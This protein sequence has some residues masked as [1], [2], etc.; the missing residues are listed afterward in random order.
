MIL[1]L[2]F[3]FVFTAFSAPPDIFGT[4]S[5]YGYNKIA[6]A[7]HYEDVNTLTQEGKLRLKQLQDDSY[8]CKYKHSSIFSCKKFIPTENFSYGGDVSALLPFSF[9]EIEFP[10]SHPVLEYS[11]GDFEEWYLNQK[12][13]TSGDHDLYL[14]YVKSGDAEKLVLR[15]RKD[16]SYFTE[17]SLTNTGELLMPLIIREI[18]DSKSYL[19]ILL[20]LSWGPSH[21]R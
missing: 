12:V 14:K 18:I 4:L 16:Q 20:L 10:I 1:N 9:I 2:L 6:Q 8:T 21:G 7:I 19:D 5:Y 17:F 11:D 13:K 15:N 3:S